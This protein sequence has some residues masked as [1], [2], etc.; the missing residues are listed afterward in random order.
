VCVCLLKSY[1]KSYVCKCVFV[2]KRERDGLLFFF[3]C[4]CYCLVEEKKN[5]LSMQMRQLKQALAGSC[6]TAIVSATM[7]SR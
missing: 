5:V 1:V 3:V 6:S 4:V 7:T 2:C